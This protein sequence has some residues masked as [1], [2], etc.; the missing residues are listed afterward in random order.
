MHEW[1]LVTGL[2]GYHTV[3]GG[4]LYQVSTKANGVWS[5]PVFV[6]D[7]PVMAELGTFDPPADDRSPMTDDAL[8]AWLTATYG[9]PRAADRWEPVGWIRWNTTGEECVYMD[10]TEHDTDGDGRR[11]AF[12]W[13]DTDE[14]LPA[15]V[16]GPALHAAHR[17]GT[18]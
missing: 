10:T 7:P 18:P 3:P 6:A 4:R 12:G 17:Y 1:T 15:H 5:E 2:I 14:Q 11:W 16:A 8:R 13:Q 9:E